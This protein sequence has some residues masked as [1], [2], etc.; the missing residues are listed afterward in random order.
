LVDLRQKHRAQLQQD[1]PYKSFFL[2]KR[3]LD[4]LKKHYAAIRHRQKATTIILKGLEVS[5]IRVPGQRSNSLF[6][7]TTKKVTLT[8]P[9]PIKL[10]RGS[11]SSGSG[12]KATTATAQQQPLATSNNNNNNNRKNIN[13]NNRHVVNGHH[14]PKAKQIT[15]TW[16]KTP[17]K[18]ATS[19]AGKTFR[20]R[21]TLS[22]S[23]INTTSSSSSTELCDSSDDD[24][25]SSSSSSSEGVWSDSDNKWVEKKNKKGKVSR[26]PLPQDSSKENETPPEEEEEG[27]I[28]PPSPSSDPV[29]QQNILSRSSSIIDTNDSQHF[30]EEMTK[31]GKSDSFYENLSKRICELQFQNLKTL[32]NC[33]TVI[34]PKTLTLPPFPKSPLASPLPSPFFAPADENLLL[35]ARLTT[36]TPSPRGSISSEVSLGSPLQQQGQRSRASSMS[37]RTP[38]KGGSLSSLDIPDICINDK[39]EEPPNKDSS[40]K[41]PLPAGSISPTE[42]GL[43]WTPPPGP[44]PITEPELQLD[45][46]ETASGLSSLSPLL[47]A[48][49]SPQTFNHLEDCQNNMMT[50]VDPGQRSPSPSLLATGFP[51]NLQEERREE[52]KERCSFPTAICPGQFS[53]T[54]SP[55]LASSEEEIK[56]NAVI[57]EN[58]A[59]LQRL[60]LNKA[61][62]LDDYEDEEG[63]DES[64]EDAGSEEEINSFADLLPADDGRRSGSLG[65]DR[66][67]GN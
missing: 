30:L 25:S 55:E 40:I 46:P 44:L 48:P 28:G 52:E 15:M 33:N 22:S 60:K 3:E 61:A 57:R 8:S 49:I 62:Y 6:I 18:A 42:L 7:P 53:T 47:T 14:Q 2:A 20:R 34:D 50:L 38:S 12:S 41:F 1:T 5:R 31:L 58:I 21:R 66:D 32:S 24:G 23:S 10:R 19:K 59:I 4:N 65:S 51:F 17:K 63:D 13:N 16:D 45:F 39:N 26:P 64:Y 29:Q 11:T 9:K 35:G 36:T 27:G 56:I 37:K 43:H 54:T 67:S